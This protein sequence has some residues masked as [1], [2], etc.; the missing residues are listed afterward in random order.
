VHSTSH[1][2]SQ[3]SQEALHLRR[4]HTITDRF[5]I[6]NSYLVNEKRLFVIDPGSN[7]NVRLLCWY[8]QHILHRPIHDI[9]LI[10]LTHWNPDQITAAET[11]RNVCH[12][13]IA[14][15]ADVQQWLTE[16]RARKSVSSLSYMAKRLLPG[17]QQHLDRFQSDYEHQARQISIW[18]RDIEGLPGHLDWRVIA[19]PGHSPEGLCLYNPFTRELLCGDTVI[20]MRGGAPVVRSSTNPLQLEEMIR[21]LR[22][23]PISYLYPGHGRAILSHHPFSNLDVEW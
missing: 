7:G 5:S 8:V 21:L 20:T 23:L 4:V 16:Q 12:A 10:V 2:Q 6:M 19:S 9:D 17:P 22:S 14:A 18:L 11:L 3:P 1:N 15:S 13:P